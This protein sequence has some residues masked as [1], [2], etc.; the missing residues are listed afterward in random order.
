[1]LLMSRWMWQLMMPSNSSMSTA[2][3]HDIFGLQLPD[4]RDDVHRVVDQLTKAN[5]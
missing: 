3:L 4:W 1:M 5:A 2:K